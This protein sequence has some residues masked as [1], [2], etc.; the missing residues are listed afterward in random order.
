MEAERLVAAYVVCFSLGTRIP[1]RFDAKKSLHLER[2]N[3]AMDGFPCA[4]ER[5]T[6]IRARD[7]TLKLVNHRA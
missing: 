1:A 4:K 7:V 6:R 3:L 2:A 5:H